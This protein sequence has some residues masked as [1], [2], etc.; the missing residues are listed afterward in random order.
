MSAMLP[1]THPPGRFL[2]SRNRTE[3][4]PARYQPSKLQCWYDNIIDRMLTHPE[5][6][7][8]EIAREVGCSPQMIY[9][10]TNCDLFRARYA[11]RRREFEE[12]L[13]CGI[14]DRAAQV[15]AKSLEPISKSPAVVDPL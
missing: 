6:T 14:V 11:Q 12:C 10:V 1:P 3:S 8:I 4:G 15:A 9:L 13:G 2:G 5:Y 7:K